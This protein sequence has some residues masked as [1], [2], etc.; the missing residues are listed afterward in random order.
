ME[1]AIPTQ[2]T[3]FAKIV[4]KNIT[5]QVSYYHYMLGVVLLHPDRRE[6][7]PLAPEPIVKSDGNTKN[8]C[9]RNAAKRLL[10]DIR[11]EHP[12]LKIIITED[13]LASNGPHIRLLKEL[14]MRF[15]LGV[16]PTD[17]T[18]LF[19]WVSAFSVETL[20]KI[21]SDGTRRVYHG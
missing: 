4:V 6:V 16:K 10:A 19:D 9:E 20:E 5:Q 12:H 11:R 3:C 18:F 13:S 1:Q 7:I 15:I 14:N 21:E 17:H 8:D 2:T